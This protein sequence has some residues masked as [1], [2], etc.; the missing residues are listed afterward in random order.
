[1]NVRRD[2]AWTDGP[3]CTHIRNTVVDPS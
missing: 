1:M 3:I 2:S